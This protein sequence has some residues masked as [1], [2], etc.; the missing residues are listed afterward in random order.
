MLRSL[1]S[2]LIGAAFALG[3][4][5][6]EQEQAAVEPAAPVNPGPPGLWAV[7]LLGV[8]GGMVG[9]ARVCDD[10]SLRAAFARG[11]PTPDGEVCT[12]VGEPVIGPDALTA[13][14]RVGDVE[15]VAE[16]DPQGDLT[17]VFTMEMVIRSS[18]EA[19]AEYHQT[20][21]YRRIGECPA[22]WTHGDSAAPGSS[23]IV[24]VFTGEAKT[25]MSVR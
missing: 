1:T 5:A 24:N 18:G 16:T 9:A 3:A 25:G 17:R 2:I 19:P 11:L 12:L 14:C 4:C 20:A 13:N 6:G 7:E 22:D 8:D 15:Y 21:R 10:G 23:D